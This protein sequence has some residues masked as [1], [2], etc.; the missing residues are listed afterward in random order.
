MTRVGAENTA[1]REA[2]FGGVVIIEANFNNA[3]LRS[4]FSP[5]PI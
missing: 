2:N 1:M 5:E 4:R 3:D